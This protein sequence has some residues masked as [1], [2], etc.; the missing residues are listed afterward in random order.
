MWKWNK[1]LVILVFGGTLK[2]Q[3]CQISLKG[4]VFDEVTGEALPFATIYLE[5]ISKGKS[6]D[7]DGYFEFAG[8]CPTKTHLKISHVS[9]EPLSQYL[10]IKNDTVLNIYLHHHEELMDEVLVHGD[11]ADFSTQNSNTID[12]DLIAKESNK[13][14]SDLLQTIS[15]VS[16]LKTGSGISKPIIDGLYGNRITML[17]NGIEQAGQ[18]W[19]NDHAPEIDPFSA[20]HISVIK[21]V[22]ALEYSGSSLGGV[23]LIEPDIIEH[24]PHLHGNVNYIFQSNGRGHTFNTELRKFSKGLGWRL[25]A[26][27][28]GIGDQKTPNYYLTNS[29]RRE[30][31]GSIQLEKVIGK[32]NSSLYFS[33]FNTEIGILR[34]AHVGNLTDLESAF[35][36]EEPFFTSEDFSYEIDA[37]SQKVNHHLLKLKT[38]KNYK[39]SSVLTFQYAGQIDNRKEFD[40]RRA[41]RSEQAA[42]SLFQHSHFLE[43]SYSTSL[44]NGAFVKAGIQGDLK[45]NT[46]NPE[47]GILPL[48][49]DYVA[50]TGSIFAFYQKESD[51]AFYEFGGRT[52]IRQLNAATISRDLPR[53]IV[54]YNRTFENYSIS[55]GIKYSFSK[56]FKFNLNAGYTLRAP[57]VNELY[58]FGLHQGVSSIEVGN[59]DL[60]S[61]KSFKVTAALDLAIQKKLFFQVLTYYQ[62][63]RDFIYLQAQTENTLTIRGAFPIFNYEQTNAQLIGADF[64]LSFEPVSHVRLVSKAAILKGTDLTNDKPLVYMPSNNWSNTLKF[65]IKEFTLSLEHQVVFEQKNLEADQDFL[66]PPATYQLINLGF[67][68][69]LHIKKNTLGLGLKI[70]NVLNEVYRD[71]LNRQRYFADELGRSINV[72]VNYKF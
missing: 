39:N 59:I 18:Q 2:A 66:P 65:S 14:I 29:G 52:D 34:G 4:R 12:K 22:S 45:D 58:S 13:S 50:L 40:V 60:E 46:N 15:G 6:A 41:G 35:D 24:E 28:K 55:S 48:I 16:S 69:S 67:N 5:S 38:A 68:T 70:E 51:K 7:I 25:N 42:L 62:N 63:I 72:R 37:P 56:A 17:N 33:T 71:Y 61:E 9:C 27:I 21:G 54:R 43:G 47:T 36:R 19:G 53:K 11:R 8:L 44:R 49:P 1:I 57:A 20:G 10:V 31:N 3:D 26:S 64:L 32:W 30:A 23:V